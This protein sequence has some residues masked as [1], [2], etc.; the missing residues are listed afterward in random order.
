VDGSDDVKTK[1]ALA[2]SA[3]LG[4]LAAAGCAGHHHG[5]IWQLHE[6]EADQCKYLGSVEIT[7]RSGWGMGEADLGASQEVR[8]RVGELGGNAFARTHGRSVAF[9]PGLQVD[10]YKCP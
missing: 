1:A 4:V 5:R 3:V 7:G 9:G 2:T 8:A 10:V 6:G